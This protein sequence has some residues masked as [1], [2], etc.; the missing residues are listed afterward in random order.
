MTE[1]YLR[2]E[3]H[4]SSTRNTKPSI[5]NEKVTKKHTASGQIRSTRSSENVVYISK[6]TSYRQAR[7][8]HKQD[9]KSV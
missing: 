1:D 8:V 2:Y 4:H 7:Y 6:K 5:Q 3:L 9:K